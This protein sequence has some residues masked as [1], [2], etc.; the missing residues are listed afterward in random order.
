MMS[1]VNR[2]L[3]ALAD[4]KFALDQHAIVTITNC[5]G[6]ITYANEQLCKISGYSVEEIIDRNVNI[7]DS[8]LHDKHFF[9]AIAQNLKAG[10]VWQG[11]MSHRA[12]DGHI[13]WV[14]TTIVPLKDS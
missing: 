13:F 3:Q 4:Q 9:N 8:G 2:S 6:T 5:Q 14:N 10:R 12:K 7:F 11:E 1:T